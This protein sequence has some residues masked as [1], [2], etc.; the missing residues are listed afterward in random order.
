MSEHE[1][2]DIEIKTHLQN[3]KVM[4]EAILDVWQ[5]D[6]AYLQ[7]QV[8]GNNDPQVLSEQVLNPRQSEEYAQALIKLLLSIQYFITSNERNELDSLIETFHAGFIHENLSY[9]QLFLASPQKTIDHRIIWVDNLIY[10]LQER[11]KQT[12]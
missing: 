1:L 7:R 11:V 9:T 3:A 4:W 8:D 5:A 6:K 2:S 10:S 12:Q